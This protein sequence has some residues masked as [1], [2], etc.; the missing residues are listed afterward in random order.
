[1]SKKSLKFALMFLGVLV[2]IGLYIL[3]YMDYTSKT[4]ALDADIA[5][6]TTRLGTLTTY[7]SNLPKYTSGIAQTKSMIGE[8]LDKYTSSE[9]PEDFIMLA[10]DLE[11]NVGL[12]VTGMTFGESPAIYTIN[13]VKDGKDS[14]APV[15]PIPLTCFK[16]SATLSATMKYAQLKQTLD[17]ISAQKD[18]TKLNVLTM[19]YDSST[20]LIAGTF[21]LDKYYITGRGIPE[22]Q[23]TIPYTA[24]GKNVLIGT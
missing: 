24:L 12:T 9:R 22:H 10:T 2:F 8:A 6:L 7:S 19:T 23:A 4:E 5:K 15:S 16:T 21:S 17:S 11:K 3:V 14:K 1:M 20:G 18:V 13:G